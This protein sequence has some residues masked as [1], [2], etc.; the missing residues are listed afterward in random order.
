M[1]SVTVLYKVRARKGC[2]PGFVLS[3]HGR[4]PATAAH[5]VLAVFGDTV[6]ANRILPARSI[7]ARFSRVVRENGRPDS[8]GILAPV[9]VLPWHYGR[10]IR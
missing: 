8:F 4:P 9:G 5:S 7:R 6:P 2:R 1:H 10:G 3:F